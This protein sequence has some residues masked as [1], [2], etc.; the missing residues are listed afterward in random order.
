MYNVFWD[1][2]FCWFE[3]VCFCGFV[4]SAHTQR[5]KERH[6]SLKKC[7]F[8]INLSFHYWPIWFSAIG[9]VSKK[10]LPRNS[11]NERKKE[12][13]VT[14]G[15]KYFFFYVSHLSIYFWMTSWSATFELLKGL[16]YLCSS[17]NV[18]A[19]GKPPKRFHKSRR[20]F[21]PWMLLS[22]TF[23]LAVLA[24]WRDFFRCCCC[25]CC[26]PMFLFVHSRWF[27]FLLYSMWSLLFFIRIRFAH[28]SG[29]KC[30]FSLK[31]PSHKSK[32]KNILSKL[33]LILPRRARIVN[34]F[35]R[36][37]CVCV[38]FFFLSRKEE[39]EMIFVHVWPCR[40]IECNC[41]GANVHFIFKTGY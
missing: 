22:K 14:A 16:T 19:S 37:I 38:C 30:V 9:A 11:N 33:C 32:C 8:L 31:V 7:H 21:L 15:L 1:M 23:S 6:N 36:H 20:R 26:P 34:G 24:V 41:H 35:T 39:I 40:H 4:Y 25:C 27:S 5:E 17:S 3:H 10:K 29:E 28:L 13:E 12:Y 18:S 2:K